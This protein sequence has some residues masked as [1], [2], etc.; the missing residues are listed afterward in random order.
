MDERKNKRLGFNKKNAEKDM[1]K[2]HGEIMNKQHDCN[3][4]TESNVMKRPIEKDT[5]KKIVKTI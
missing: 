3:Q 4:M 5:Q 1:K 2:P